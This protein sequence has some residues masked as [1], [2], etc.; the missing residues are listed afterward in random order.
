MTK[1][2]SSPFADPSRLAATVQD[3][4]KSSAEKPASLR[5]N[6]RVVSTTVDGHKVSYTVGGSGPTVVL[7]HGWGLGHRAYRPG[8]RRLAECGFSVVAPALPGFGGTP[9]LP[10]DQ[11][12]FSGYAAWVVRFVEALQIRRAVFVGHSF[13][14]GV[15]IQTAECQPGLVS[16]LV[17]LNSVGA[18]WRATKAGDQPMAK[19]PMWSWGLNIPSDVVS[20]L[21]HVGSAMPSVL[22]DLV[23]NVLRNPLGVVRIGKIAREADLVDS[24][25]EVRRRNV[26]ITIVHSIDDGVIP[27]TSF[28][29]LCKTAA[30]E[31]LVV[32][33]N[34]SW[35]MTAPE[36][37]AD[38][39][40]TAA[41]RYSA[42]ASVA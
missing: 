29:Y 37:F 42:R 2:P 19:R 5:G 21:G 25:R 24:L 4:S 33:G 39:V 27:K 26:P 7:L 18:P 20:L 30:V 13:G 9:E 32:E 11:R 6:L 34:H 31:G 22:E 14:G 16:T 41:R 35:P 3:V 1:F 23:P 40:A 28:E 8:L 17:L 36:S 38:V 15:A 12:N 10:V